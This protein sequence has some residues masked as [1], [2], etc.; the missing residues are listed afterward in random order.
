MIEFRFRFGPCGTE[1]LLVPVTEEVRNPVLFRHEQKVQLAHRALSFADGLLHELD[2]PLG[3]FHWPKKRVMV[4][5]DNCQQL[6]AQP[7]ETAVA[8]GAHEI[9]ARILDEVIQT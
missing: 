6:L 9:S 1:E 7:L 4:L 5:A 2:A 8:S 3:F